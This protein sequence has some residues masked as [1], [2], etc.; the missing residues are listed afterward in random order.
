MMPTKGF[1]IKDITE[2]KG[3]GIIASLRNAARLARDPVQFISRLK[4]DNP[5]QSIIPLAAF[6][7]RR[8]VAILNKEMGE[9]I[10]RNPHFGQAGVLMR[11][12][13]KKFGQKGPFTWDSEEVRGIIRPLFHKDELLN[14][15]KAMLLH[16]EL[17]RFVE[18]L[19]IA[20]ERMET[21]DILKMSKAASIAIVCN[22]ILGAQWNDETIQ[23]CGQDMEEMVL[24][25]FESMMNPLSIISPR[26]Y[27]QVRKMVERQHK[28]IYELMNEASTPGILTAHSLLTKLRQ[29]G[30]IDNE[31]MFSVLIQLLVAGHETTAS[32]L[33]HLT[34][35][36]AIH[37]D[38]YED[39][40]LKAEARKLVAIDPGSDW[41][42]RDFPALA[43]VVSEV[44][45]T[46]PPIISVFRAA[47]QDTLVR[48]TREESYRFNAG[49][50][51]YLPLLDY[52]HT[53]LVAGR[54]PAN[55]LATLTFSSGVHKCPGNIFAVR[56]LT[57]TL[58]TLIHRRIRF[59]I[60]STQGYTAH[61]AYKPRGLAMKVYR[62]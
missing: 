27:L 18:K 3:P 34:Q 4:A 58:A 40:G 17:M 38:M 16:N 22:I 43:R 33:A 24:A 56:L 51:V 6:G 42:Y 59:S 8:A 12:L 32:A 31:T 45:M 49:T 46:Y 28:L 30:A 36:L 10:L 44:I 7:R 35:H 48:H 14:G 15:A 52:S 29:G 5:R 60:I 54:V 50:L 39:S 23:Q 21:I 2:I 41:T 25:T 1:V 9:E 19:E 62:S 55:P 37:K 13:G 61:L 53:E 11:I 26:R 57:M 20:S 47:T